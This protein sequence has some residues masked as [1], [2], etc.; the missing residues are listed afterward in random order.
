MA[1]G[2][3][4][5]SSAH[6]DD[7]VSE[8]MAQVQAAAL[9]L[10]SK[11]EGAASA[12]DMAAAVEKAAA[13]LKLAAEMGKVRADLAKINE[14]VARL[15]RENESAPKRER[16]ERLRDYVALFTPLVTI[17]TLA[18]TLIAQNWQFLR[19]E[20]NKQEDALNA[21]RNGVSWSREFVATPVVTGAGLIPF[22]R[23]LQFRRSR[24]HCRW[25][26]PL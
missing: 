18:A 21:Q 17:I 20:R 11:A 3:P 12:A 23:V 15:K 13:A 8:Q 14:E 10:L 22:G 16:S 24:A 26:C 25:Q 7:S 19:S 2:K 5:E 1:T 4:I 6:E 9:A